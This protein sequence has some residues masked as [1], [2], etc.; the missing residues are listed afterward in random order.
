MEDMMYATMPKPGSATSV[1]EPASPPIPSGI[2]SDKK[3]E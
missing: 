1:S 2:L 3:K